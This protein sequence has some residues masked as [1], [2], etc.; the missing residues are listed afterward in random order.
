M[1][2]L[3]IDHGQAAAEQEAKAVAALAD[4]LGIAVR[5]AGLLGSRPSGPLVHGLAPGPR[6]VLFV[7]EIRKFR[8]LGRLIA[9]TVEE[10]QRGEVEG[11]LD[12]AVVEIVSADKCYSVD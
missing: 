11:R 2:G 12:L 9:P 3:F 10:D 1:N 7:A 8:V 5:K 6:H 4:H